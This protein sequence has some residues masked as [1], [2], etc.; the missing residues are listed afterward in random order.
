MAHWPFVPGFESGNTANPCL[1]DKR[2]GAE[3]GHLLGP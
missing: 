2:E 1:F 3:I